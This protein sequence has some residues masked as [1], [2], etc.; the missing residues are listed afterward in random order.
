MAIFLNSTISVVSGVTMN[1]LQIFNNEDGIHTNHDSLDYNPKSFITLNNSQIYNNSG[2]G[3]LLYRTSN[4]VVN[5]S[6]IYNNS[7]NGLY[8]AGNNNTSG[9][10]NNSAFYNNGARGIYIYSGSHFRYGKVVSFDN[11]V[12]NV[13]VVF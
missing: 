4:F 5:N 1:N 13:A 6:H 11:P 10:I 12:N 9:I 2:D 8:F 3:L 7:G